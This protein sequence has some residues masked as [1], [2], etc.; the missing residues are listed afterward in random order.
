MPETVTPGYT[1]VIF[2]LYRIDSIHLLSYLN[3]YQICL[4]INKALEIN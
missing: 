2:T 4:I 1:S 3:N